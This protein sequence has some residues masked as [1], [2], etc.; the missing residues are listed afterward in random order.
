MVDLGATT[1][2]RRTAVF[3]D[4]RDR[5]LLE[6]FRVLS[7]ACPER[8]AVRDGDRVLTYDELHELVRGVAAAI[9]ERRASADEPQ[10]VT[11]VVGHGID[12]LLTVYGV[13]AAGAV[14]VP[15]DAAEP[16]ERM[17]LLHREGGAELVVST[18]AHP[19]RV[20]EAT[21]G[22]VLLL[23]DL[24]GGGGR[25]DG[26]APEPDAL[27]MVNFTAGSTGAPKGVVR[28]HSTLVRAAFTTAQSNLIDAGDVV[29]FT[30]SF[31][32]IGAYAR[33]LGAFVAGAELC[34]HDQ[35]VGGGRELA[36]WIADRRI[37]VLQFIPSVLRNL[38]KAVGRGNVAPIDSVK[39]V[40]LGGETTYGRDVAQA[41]ELF[42]PD[43]RFVNRYG[44]SET[45]ILAEW[46]TTPDDEARGDTPLPLGR[47][48]P[49]AE[50]VVVDDAGEPVAPG[51]VGAPEVVSEHCSLGY[52]HAPELTAERFRF[53]PDGRR[54]LR[55][56]D[57][58]RQRSDGV[59]EYVAR[60]DDRVKVRGVMVGP[61]EVER[62]LV[63]L[64]GVAGAAVV[65]VA[66]PDGGTGLVGYVV[67]DGRADLSAWEVRRAL[68]AAVPSAMVP[69][70]VIVLEK[71]PL[72]PRGKI[73]RQALPEPQRS[74]RPYRPAVGP[75]FELA[76]IF[77]DVLGVERVGLD[78][79]FFELGGDSLAVVELQ[80][81]IADRLSVEV[82][83]STVL[84]S[85][86]VA[87]LF[88]R[89]SH[90]RPRNASP[91]VMLRGAATDP[92]LFC[93]A[94]AGDPALSFRQLSAAMPDRNFAA[95]QPRGL[96]ERAMAD[97]TV[98]ATA[99]RNVAAMREHQPHGPYSVAGYSYGGI[100]AFEM[101]CQLRAAGEVVAWLV[102]LDTH[103]PVGVRRADTERAA[104]VRDAVRRR[105]KVVLALTTAGWLPRRGY[106]QHEV[107]FRLNNHMSRRYVP[108][109]TF[110]GPTLVV[111][112]AEPQRT[113]S[114]R[115]SALADLGWSTLVSGPITTIEVDAQHS[116]LLRKPAVE[117]VAAHVAAAL[118]HVVAR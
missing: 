58:V 25:A 61:G 87:Q 49:W 102:L 42:G 14:L 18:A 12:A 43:A 32:F 51:E 26:A 88:L 5:S 108:S 31:S 3:P 41:R 1:P 40:S 111:R 97:R 62:A 60:A 76:A 74:S 95:I 45:S 92:P 24:V 68:A 70:S 29:A 2:W 103:A 106:H 77:G 46:V 34:V 89:L 6:V 35:R 52:W 113:A 64:D 33:S 112:S 13:M 22:R 7:V 81:E 90:R 79:D 67:P 11:A 63:S 23:T 75:E 85:P 27:A 57:H 50:I 114:R 99:R 28:D 117:L 47:A 104:D 69:G 115:Q 101:A 19:E 54:G 93:V 20:R 73:D 86:T 72:T 48:L 100:V 118:D 39:I 94:G 66:A 21:D 80:A 107:F 96:E 71:F 4:Y 56:S 9:G 105:A 36:E 59:L 44:S 30:G 98:A 110:D 8:V 16:V 84:E 38:V 116:D 83:T 37:S 91:V 15:I 55:M 109:S 82:P 53:L 17:A 10:V 65:P 78:D